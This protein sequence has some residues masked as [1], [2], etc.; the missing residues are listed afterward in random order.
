MNITNRPCQLGIHINTRSEKHGED[1]VPAVDI[2]LAGI[3]LE[4]AELDELVGANFWNAVFDTPVGDGKAPRPAW[5]LLDDFRL[6]D[7]FAGEV[8]IDLGP[9]ITPIK[10]DAVTLTKLRLEPLEGGL[11]ELS[12]TVQS[13]E[14][15]EGFVHKLVA[16]LGTEVS[17]TIAI[18]EK[19][20][21]EKSK[22]LD[23]PINNFGEDEAPD[24][25]AQNEAAAREQAAAFERGTDLAAAAE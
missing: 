23:L 5:R 21:R 13:A 3:M 12:L 2:P 10:L 25:D 7:K 22:Q 20:E 24:E 19:I 1:T 15:V 14:D 8:V 9:N 4:R 6:T 11:T 18:G 17:A 16:R